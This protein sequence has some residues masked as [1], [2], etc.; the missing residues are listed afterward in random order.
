M[1]RD[2]VESKRGEDE[3]GKTTLLLFI[4]QESK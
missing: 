1:P 3:V 2:D 4:G